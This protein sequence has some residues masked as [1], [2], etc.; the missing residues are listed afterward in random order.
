MH[1]KSNLGWSWKHE[2][3][4][5]IEALVLQARPNCEKDSLEYFVHNFCREKK[6]FFETPHAIFTENEYLTVLTV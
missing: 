2:S 1:W 5:N 6:P 4:R 3:G